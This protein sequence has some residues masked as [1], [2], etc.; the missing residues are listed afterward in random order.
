[1]AFYARLKKIKIAIHSGLGV[2]DNHV[3][4]RKNVI[5]DVTGGCTIG[6]LIF[7]TKIVTKTNLEKW[8]E[9]HF[10]CPKHM[11][12]PTKVA[13]DE[14]MQEDVVLKPKGSKKAFEESY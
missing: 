6:A 4:A 13:W 1:M 5:T 2:P 8:A 10:L 3:N 7:T 11:L 14:E 9:K 12:A